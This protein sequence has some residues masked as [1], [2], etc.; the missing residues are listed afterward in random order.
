MSQ[1]TVIR[2]RHDGHRHGLGEMM[3]HARGARIALRMRLAASSWPG[4]VLPAPHCQE[5]PPATRSGLMQRVQRVGDGRRTAQHLLSRESSREQAFRVLGGSGSGRLG[6]SDV[7]F[8]ESLKCQ[9]ITAPSS[10]SFTPHQLRRDESCS[11]ENT[12]A[13]SNRGSSAMPEAPVTG[14]AQR[15][16]A[17]EHQFAFPEQYT[18]ADFMPSPHAAEASARHHPVHEQAHARDKATQHRPAPPKLQIPLDT[19]HASDYAQKVHN[20]TKAVIQRLGN[21]PIARQAR[22]GWDTRP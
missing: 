3:R 16:F 12:G 4:L 19:P 18:G 14:A 5:T 9:A 1:R 21:G 7:W 10:I 8:F 13:L 15:G 6:F 17:G 20:P 22:H 11:L 2:A